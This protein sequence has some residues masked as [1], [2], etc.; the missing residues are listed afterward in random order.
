MDF[1]VTDITKHTWFQVVL[2]IVA[3]FVVHA[4]LKQTIG[5]LVSRA[6]ARHSYV[7]VSEREKREE[8]LNDAFLAISGVVLWFIAFIVIL[9]QL[10]INLAALLTG[11]GLV[12]VVVGFGAQDSVKDFL[13]GI[14]IIAENQFRIGDIVTLRADGSNVSG[15][16]E[17]ISVRI[18]KLRDLDGYL[19]IVQNG[20]ISTVTNMTFRFANV[21]LNVGVSYD[22]DIDAVE[23]VINSVGQSMATDKDWESHIVEPI[24]FLRVDSFD[25]SAVTIKALGKVKPG[26]QWDVAGEYR[27]RLK[28]AFEKRKIVIPFPQLDVHSSKN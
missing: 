20:S 5:I 14:Y 12:S 28:K 26:S 8:T 10:H 23:E 15:I 6:L 27:R 25:D 7:S 2:T 11:A 18:T 13:S 22:S 3:T 17:D 24:A 1:A 16:V 19:H 21:N 9:A 4:I